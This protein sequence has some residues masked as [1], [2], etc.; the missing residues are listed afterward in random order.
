LYYQCSVSNFLQKLDS[1][2]ISV[3]QEP[4]PANYPSVKKDGNHQIHILSEH[5][6][7]SFPLISYYRSRRITNEMADQYLREVRYQNGDK[8]HDALGFKNDSGGYELRSEHFKGSSSP[9]DTT[10]LDN[11][12]KELAVFEGFFNFL[13]Y[14]NIHLHQEE[15]L[16]NFLILNSASFFEKSLAKMRTYDQVH[17]Y[18]DNDKTGQKYTQQALVLDQE[19]FTDERRLYQGY[20]DLNEWIIHI[21]QSQKQQLRLKP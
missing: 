14:K 1:M 2:G 15:P 11:G 19:K 17:L 5:L 21:G 16:R 20:K 3:Q 10:F 6:I 12:S 8:M 13:S 9:K 7:H 4:S 18:L